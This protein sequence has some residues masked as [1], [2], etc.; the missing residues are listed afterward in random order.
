M[1]K[2]TTPEMELSIVNTLFNIRKNIIVPNVSWGMFNH[3][4]DLLVLSEKHFATEIEIKVSKADLKADFKKWHNHRDKRIK[5]LYYAIPYY[6]ENCIDLIPDY[7]GVIIVQ[8]DRNHAG[9]HV[10][11]YLRKAV[12][13]TACHS[14]MSDKDVMQLTRLGCLR[15]WSLREKVKSLKKELENNISALT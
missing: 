3:E 14:P 4:C 1:G 5:Y 10:A 13:N 7:A 12:A 15:I 6:M 11:E 9:Y 8:E 2:I